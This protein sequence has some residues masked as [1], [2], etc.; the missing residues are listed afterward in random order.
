VKSSDEFWTDVG[1][2]ARLARMVPLR[3]A[4]QSNAFQEAARR[5]G[6]VIPLGRGP[7]GIETL[8]ILKSPHLLIAGAV[9]SGKTEFVYCV[10]ASLALVSDAEE[11]RLLLIDPTR[12]ELTSFN[13][14]P[15]LAAPVVVDV[16]E[17]IDVLRGVEGEIRARRNRLAS[18]GVDNIESYNSRNS[19]EKMPYLVIVI[20]EVSDLMIGFPG[21][22]EPLICGLA[23]SSPAVG[24]HLV[25]AT[26]RPAVDVVT[27]ALKASFPARLCFAVVSSTDS[28]VVLDRT[29][30]ERL[31]D[32]D[33]LYMLSSDT[34][35]RRLRGCTVSYTEIDRIV[36]FFVE[37]GKARDGFVGRL[38]DE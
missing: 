22:V 9:L 31:E 36:S 15:H 25:V 19:I 26:Q 34:E 32:G 17:A 14:L 2:E 8:D 18:V 38:W 20:Y 13:G 16:D 7:Q 4:I 12:V 3:V 30:A 21:I 1:A 23:K 37:G 24:I 6:L 33:V 10:V 35:P 27:P 28:M 29:G 5:S 11:V